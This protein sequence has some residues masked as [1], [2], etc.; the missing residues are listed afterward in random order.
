MKKI[1]ILMVF[2]FSISPS[3]ADE[4]NIWKYSDFWNFW[5][6]LDWSYFY[7]FNDMSQL[8]NLF[9]NQN[10][11][12]FWIWFNDNNIK[13][14]VDFNETFI[15]SDWNKISISYNNSANKYYIYEN[16][17]KWQEYDF[18][19]EQITY[20]WNKDKYFFVSDS[21]WSN[22]IKN[23]IDDWK[24]F[25][26]I[27]S[28]ILSW[29][30]YWFIWYNIDKKEYKIIINWKEVYTYDTNNGSNQIYK[31]YINWNNLNYALIV[32]EI[33]KSYVIYNWIKSKWYDLINY[34]NKDAFVFS[35]DWKNYVF[36][37]EFFWEWKSSFSKNIIVKNGV[38]YTWYEKITNIQFDGNNNL[39]FLAYKDSKRVFVKN[40][41][42][43]LISQYSSNLNIVWDKI[44]YINSES[45]ENQLSEN[46]ILKTNYNRLSN[47]KNADA[48]VISKNK[49][50]IFY[51]WEKDNKKYAVFNWKESSNYYQLIY[52]IIISDDWKNYT[53]LWTRDW[54][55]LL[56]LNDTEINITPIIYGIYRDMKIDS[57]VFMPYDWSKVW[58]I[59]TNSNEEYILIENINK[60]I[61]KETVVNKVIDNKNA[62]LDKQLDKFF[63]K[64][65][66]MW[67]IKSE[68]TYNKL[69]W[70]IEVLL[71]K[72]LTPKN[73]E[74]LNH[75]KERLN[76][77]L[78]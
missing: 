72:K 48:F 55:E 78:N 7:S 10:W 8:D 34:N 42:N 39:Y 2:L 46:H 51:I 71:L 73:K 29:N 32:K 27:S 62:L 74:L 67:K 49:E 26:S 38:E 45:W 21:K 57:K 40:F 24:R 65:D 1:I 50:S 31:L 13:S 36:L 69:L 56:V 68:E 44:Y 16:L 15:K 37:A 33:D 58:V 20:L 35:N 60:N 43:K 22:L 59:W 64:I 12:K 63:V 3:F 77:K 70:K 18:I 54:E 75:I 61:N 47:T 5:Y 23:G 53:F 30:N 4:T 9:W 6:N 17:I 52:N 28:F 76:E 41:E 25:H 14:K 11:D 66:N 19:S